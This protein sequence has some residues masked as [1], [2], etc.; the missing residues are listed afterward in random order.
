MCEV[1]PCIQ[2]TSVYCIQNYTNHLGNGLAGK[3]NLLLRNMFEKR[4]Y[5]LL[6]PKK[7]WK[8]SSNFT[9]VYVYQSRCLSQPEIWSQIWC[10]W[11]SPHVIWL[12][13]TPSWV[14]ESLY[15]SRGC[16]WQVEPSKDHHA[17][18]CSHNGTFS[19]D[20]SL[21]SQVFIPSKFET[22]ENYVKRKQDGNSME[23]KFTETTQ[24]WKLRPAKRYWDSLLG[25]SDSSP[26]CC[27]CCE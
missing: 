14:P 10:L 16:P 24:A 7:P 8:T 11:I 13:N 4:Y 19:S 9:T 15:L 1:Q 5:L 27:E 18:K 17:A 22:L 25:P 6:N 26:E 23:L 2:Y 21:K 20:V 12:S 3:I